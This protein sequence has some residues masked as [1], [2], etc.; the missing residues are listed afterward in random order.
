MKAKAKAKAEAQV[1]NITFCYYCSPALLLYGA[2]SKTS[3]HYL[4]KLA[5]NL[6]AISERIAEV[7][8]AAASSKS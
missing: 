5:E 6:P 3:S 2:H 8:V 4:S 1:V 7:Y